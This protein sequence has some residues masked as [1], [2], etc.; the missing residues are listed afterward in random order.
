MLQA[1]LNSRNPSE[2]LSGRG[3]S[4]QIVANKSSAHWDLSSGESSQR[5]QGVG[6]Q[7]GRGQCLNAR[8]ESWEQISPCAWLLLWISCQG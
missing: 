6:T 1:L 4:R 5:S 7:R 2:L 3:F 8:C